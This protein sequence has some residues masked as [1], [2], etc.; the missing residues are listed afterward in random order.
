MTREPRGRSLFIFLLM[1]VFS[2][3]FLTLMRRNFMTLPLFTTRHLCT[4]IFFVNN[5]YF[6]LIYLKELMRASN[7]F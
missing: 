1:T 4:K 3:P 6:K 7:S 2:Q 5:N